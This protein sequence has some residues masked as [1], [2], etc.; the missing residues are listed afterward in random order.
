MVITDFNGLDVYFES[1]SYINVFLIDTDWFK[2]YTDTKTEIKWPNKRRWQKSYNKE[3]IYILISI[4]DN[5]QD[6][7]FNAY[8]TDAVSIDNGALKIKPELT[9]SRF[10]EGYLNEQWD[11]SNM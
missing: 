10:H 4:V 11:L 1:I 6:Y 2:C 8:I 3:I 7:P 9:E 5:L